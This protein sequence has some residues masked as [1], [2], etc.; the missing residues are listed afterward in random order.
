LV[1][2]EKNEKII[3]KLEKKLCILYKHFDEKE[4]YLNINNI[5]NITEKDI[6]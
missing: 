1:G 2:I 6:E 4:I 5:N 3:N